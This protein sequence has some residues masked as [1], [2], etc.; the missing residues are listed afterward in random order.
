MFKKVPMSL[1]AITF[2]SAGGADAMSM[3]NLL[4][5]HHHHSTISDPAFNSA[6]GYNVTTPA[7]SGFSQSD[8][9]WNSADGHKNETAAAK[10]DLH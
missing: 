10:L 4:Q 3:Q 7:Y 5:H 1:A 8:P 2:F 6:E 9:A